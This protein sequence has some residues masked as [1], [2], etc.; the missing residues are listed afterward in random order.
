MNPPN[1]VT[2]DLPY[3]TTRIYTVVEAKSGC[4]IYIPATTRKNAQLTKKFYQDF[5]DQQ[6]PQPPVQPPPR[7][8]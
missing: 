1:S 3:N 4:K 2:F 5:L 7:Y 8:A 6:T